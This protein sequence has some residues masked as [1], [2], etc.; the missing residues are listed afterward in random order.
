MKLL[1]MSVRLFIYGFFC[2]SCIKLCTKIAEEN[3][4]KERPLN[5]KLLNFLSNLS[6][7]SLSKWQIIE[8]RFITL[9]L[10]KYSSL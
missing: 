7:N 5:N 10:E 6:N 8:R 1:V 9:S 3:L 4:K 2:D